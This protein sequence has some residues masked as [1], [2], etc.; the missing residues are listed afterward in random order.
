MTAFMN[1]TR[2]IQSAAIVAAACLAP[3]YAW[4]QLHVSCP[5]DWS[6]LS[7]LDSSL[8]KE[9]FGLRVRDWKPEHISQMRQQMESCLARSGWPESLKGATRKDANRIAQN[10]FA[11]LERRDRVLQAERQSSTVA[12]RLSRA[13]IPGVRL[14]DGAL[15]ISGPDIYEEQSCDSDPERFR[16]L[17]RNRRDVFVAF[18]SLCTELRQIS[19]EQSTRLAALLAEIQREDQGVAALASRV[20]AFK[21]RPETVTH[22][23]LQQVEWET[24]QV[25]ERLR[26]RPEP[27]SDM[28]A[29]QGS[30]AAVRRALDD[31]ECPNYMRQA[32]MPKDLMTAQYLIERRNPDDLENMVCWATRNGAKVSYLIGGMGR[33]EGFEIKG[34]VAVQVRADRSFAPDGKT[35][36]LVPVRGAING[37]PV[38]VTGENF[39]FFSQ[40]LINAIN[41]R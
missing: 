9:I 40:H 7:G 17:A 19:K 27:H 11:A 33:K 22:Q 14:K 1:W 26:S 23:Q 34:K 38:M 21:A 32:G 35:I 28:A 15:L 6:R 30:L 4:A 36:I 2:A 29:L 25:A 41:N 39:R 12:E 16:R 10:A 18:T 8:D 31:R 24:Q 3:G 20:A 13:N 37:E 5:V